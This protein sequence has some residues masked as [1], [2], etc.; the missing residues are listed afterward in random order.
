MSAYENVV[1][2][3][4]RLKGKALDVRNAGIKKKRKHKERNI[5]SEHAAGQD[6]LTDENSAL[7]SLDNTYW[8]GNGGEDERLTPADRRY[9]E[10]RKKIEMKRLVK[11][12]KKSH[13]D[14]IEEFNQYLANLSEHYD[15]PKVGLANNYASILYFKTKLMY[16]SQSPQS[17]NEGCIIHISMVC[18][19]QYKSMR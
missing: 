12:A 9:M 8:D 15:I 17:Y 7:V 5:L 18:H 14:R 13:R 6:R 3:K 11:A 16:F 19:S 10:Q 2:G 1:A 4:L